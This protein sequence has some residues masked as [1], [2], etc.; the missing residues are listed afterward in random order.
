MTL[1][2]SSPEEKKARWA[3]NHNKKRKERYNSD[4]QYKQ[5]R[6]EK[7]REDY[8][9]E[10]G[11]VLDSCLDRIRE[12]RSYG[13]SREVRVNDG[14]VQVR[15]CLTTQELG[16]IIG[17]HKASVM[18]RWQGKGLLPKPIAKGRVFYSTTGRGGDYWLNDQ[19]V[20]LE[21]E[22]AAIMQP[23]GEHQ[24]NFRYYRTSDTETVAAI[25]DAVEAVR[26]SL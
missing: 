8:R 21:E 11:V 6:L 18:Y 23:L 26:Q 25:F 12:I 14:P 5:A 16:E 22:V 24:R 19:P 10:K 17:G 4:P 3:D 20:Y 9:N 1:S 2:S 13:S 15:F 7:A